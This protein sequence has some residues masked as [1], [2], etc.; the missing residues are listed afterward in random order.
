MVCTP[1]ET[2]ATIN[3]FY[4]LGFVFGIILFPLPITF[5]RKKTMNI[6]LI[7]NLVASAMSIYG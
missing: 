7:F 2:I 3:S 4:F 5:G 1:A 6:V